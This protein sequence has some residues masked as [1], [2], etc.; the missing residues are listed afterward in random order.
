MDIFQWKQ[1][2]IP[3]TRIKKL[4]S[5]GT[6]KAKAYEWGSSRKQYWR[7]S[8]SPVV[9]RTLDNSYW[10]CLGFKSLSDRYSL[11]RHT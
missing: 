3:S 9:Q 11:I 6:T 10:N 8:R 4:L 7:I 5:L 1:W 2:K